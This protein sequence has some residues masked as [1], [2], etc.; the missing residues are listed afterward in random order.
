MHSYKKD[1]N[2][3]HLIMEAVKDFDT[4][5][6]LKVAP[7]LDRLSSE[8]KQSSSTTI[9]V[10]IFILLTI[11][12]FIASL[13]RLLT[14]LGGLT[15]TVLLAAT[16]YF[17]YKASKSSDKYI[18][19]FKESIIAEII[20]YLQPDLVYKPDEVVPEREY[21]QSGLFRRRY[22]YYYGDD[23]IAGVY[24]GISFHCSELRTTFLGGRQNE[25]ITIFKGLFFAAKINV[26]FTG[27]TYVW[28]QDE[29]Q[30]GISIAD[31]RY[32]LLAFPQVY[33]MKMH[34]EVFD[35]YFFVCST[36]PD[37]ARKILDNDM[38][39]RLLEFR[40]QIKRKVVFSFVMGR[41]YVAIPIAED[42]LEPTDSLDD[43]EEVKKYF[44][45]VLLIRIIN[46]LDLN[47][48]Q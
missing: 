37:E 41:C 6:A 16:I 14:P 36:K 12:S 34:D 10:V 43:K 39:R 40:K 3:Y 31:E 42:L 48:L 21:R 45:T 32:R 35:K 28:I 2:S 29:E 15:T 23:Y 4:F 19:D 38:M 17:I 30:Y 44:F 22:D 5:Y 47:K 26:A 9:Q 24:K 18:A 1:I 13:N 11:G 33:D 25:E 46:Q 7:L 27:G 20:H 8:K